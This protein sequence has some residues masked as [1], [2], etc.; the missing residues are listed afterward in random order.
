MDIIAHRG[1]SHDAPENTL[2]AIRLGF[3]Q[4]AD[5]VEIDL[6]LT[7]DHRVVAMHDLTARRTGRLRRAIRHLDLAQLKALDVGAWQ[8]RAWAGER[9]PLLEEVLEI[10]PPE[11]GLFLE[12]KSGPEILPFLLPL[13]KNRPGIALISFHQG[14][15]VQARKVSRAI[16][17]YWLSA[18][19]RERRF[20]HRKPTPAQLL[21]ISI[22]SNF[23]G[24]N[25]ASRRRLTRDFIDLAHAAGQKIYVWTTD[26][27]RRARR[28][29]SLGINGLTTN[30]PGWL[31]AKLAAS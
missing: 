6:Q 21:E 2:A 3:A 5:A 12:I 15:L 14:T 26:Q 7:R 29:E 9:V 30:R 25:L 10:L 28:W 18:Y 13:V 27:P 1:A 4:G 11:K 19:H 20:R 17:L 23:N 8:G 22:N 16:P 24:L 31:R